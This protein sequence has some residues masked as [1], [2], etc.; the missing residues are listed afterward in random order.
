MENTYP[1][2]ALDELS[3][4]SDA[5]TPFPSIASGSFLNLFFLSDELIFEIVRYLDPTDMIVFGSSCQRY[6]QLVFSSPKLWL[7]LD[8]NQKNALG[9]PGFQLN[10]RWMVKAPYHMPILAQRAC[11]SNAFVI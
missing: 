4:P 11:T 10:L 1:N 9:T 5:H 8:P 7:R 6:F 3:N 2:A